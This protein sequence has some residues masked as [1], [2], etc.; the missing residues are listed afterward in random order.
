MF[1]ELRIRR[2][3]LTNRVAFTSFLLHLR[4]QTSHSTRETHELPSLQAIT[5]PNYSTLVA[6]WL[7]IT[8]LRRKL[9][10]TDY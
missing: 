8:A 2:R 3:I 9:Q 6:T 1:Y 7:L 4:K 10:A 5:V